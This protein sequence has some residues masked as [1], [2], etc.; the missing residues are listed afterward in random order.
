VN[1]IT[2]DNKYVS[3]NVTG[4]NHTTDWCEMT[5]VGEGTEANPYKIYNVF[6]LNDLRNYLGTTYADTNFTLERNIDFNCFDLSLFSDI[7]GFED[8][9]TNGW[10]PIGNIYNRFKGN[11]DGKNNVIRNLYVYRPSQ[12]NVGLFSVS[13]NSEI[14]NVGLEDVN[15]VGFFYVSTLVGSNYGC[16]INK[17]YST[18][19]V[20]GTGQYVGGLVANLNGNMHYSFFVGSV[21]GTYSVGGLVGVLGEEG[22]GNIFNSYFRGFVFGTDYYIG[23]L[24]GNN[25]GVIEKCYSTGD[26]YGTNYVGGL[27]GADEGGTIENSYWNID[28]FPTSDGGEGKTTEQMKQ[29]STFTDWDFNN[30]WQIQEGTTYPYLRK[31]PQYL[32]PQ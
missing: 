10:E 29:K 18:G 5:L 21:F 8:Y 16:I 20:S 12:Y 17:C 26:V 3:L 31:N 24:V 2:E 25:F 1:L 27:L 32:P 23:G 13:Q 19:S 11:F 9:D 28:L 6:Q 7:E 14:K 22:D 30:V 15:V 4:Y